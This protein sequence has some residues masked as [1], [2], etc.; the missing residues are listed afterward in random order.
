MLIITSLSITV[1]EVLKKLYPKDLKKSEKQALLEL[2]SLMAFIKEA[3]EID[4][5]EEKSYIQVFK[6]FNKAYKIFCRRNSIRSTT[7]NYSTYNGVFAKFQVKV[8]TPKTGSKN[9]DKFGQNSKYIIGLK[10]TDNW[11]QE[12]Q[13]S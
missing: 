8:E 11:K 7:L 13:Q 4:E 2:N 12:V 5:K 1:T 3:C 10:L 6:E 9:D